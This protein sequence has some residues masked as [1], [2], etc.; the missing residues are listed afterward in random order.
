MGGGGGGGLLYMADLMLNIKHLPLQI[1]SLPSWMKSVQ[2]VVFIFEFGFSKVLY[3]E[4][5]LLLLSVWVGEV[6]PN[7]FH[8]IRKVCV[9]VCVK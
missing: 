3:G 6:T 2:D 9:C 7:R 8:F 1:Y 5:L 4:L